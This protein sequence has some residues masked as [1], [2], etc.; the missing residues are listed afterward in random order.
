LGGF[1][2]FGEPTEPFLLS[3]LIQIP[4]QGRQAWISEDGGF[5][6]KKVQKR[7]FIALA[8]SGNLS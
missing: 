6:Q 3:S 5:R 4:A 8:S 2:V 7:F 1:A